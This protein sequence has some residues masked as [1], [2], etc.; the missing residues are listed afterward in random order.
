MGFLPIFTIF[1]LLILALSIRY[2]MLDKKQSDAQEDYT[3]REIEANSTIRRDIDLNNLNY[4]TIPMD[5][6]PSESN[7]NEELSQALTALH[8]LSKQ[9]ILNLTKMTNTDLK[10]EYGR[11][12]LDEMEQIGENYNQLTILLVQIAEI[13]YNNNDYNGAIK[14]LEYGISTG[15]DVNK[16]YLLLADCY[17][18]LGKS[19]Q[20]NTLREQVEQS[21]LTLRTSILKHI[22]ES[23][24]ST[25]ASPEENFPIH[26]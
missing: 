9:R 4:I 8:A 17:T 18:I 19:R 2:R 20:L 10:L 14:I 15:T 21:D 5:K 16:N 24:E 22:D 1:L 12:H 13:L 26:S 7:G 6:F 25:A 3:R 23:L 11:N